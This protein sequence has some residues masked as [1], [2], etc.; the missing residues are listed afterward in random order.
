MRKNRRNL[1]SVLLM[2]IFSLP[3]IYQPVHRIHHIHEGNS[4]EE[5]CDAHHHHFP[6]EKNMFGI[7]LD[8]AH[9][10]CYVCDYEMVS[11]SMPEAI[12]AQSPAVICYPL[13]EAGRE[14]LVALDFN[15]KPSQRGPPIA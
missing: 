10:H 6:P 12:Q 1:V 3:L 5:C 13:L 14:V 9:E 8:A 15:D 7:Q 11:F 4:H 2:L